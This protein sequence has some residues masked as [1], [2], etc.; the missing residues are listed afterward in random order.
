MPGPRCGDCHKYVSL[1]TDTDPEVNNVEVDDDGA[2]SVE[3]RIVNTCAECGTELR[4]YTFNTDDGIQSEVATHLET[5]HN[6]DNPAE[7]TIEEMSVERTE[8]QSQVKKNAPI[9]CGYSLDY[10]IT[11]SCGFEHIDTITDDIEKSEMEDMS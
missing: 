8:R 10:K 1:D 2:V 7:L 4:D 5:E 3:V 6:Q 9:F 11:C